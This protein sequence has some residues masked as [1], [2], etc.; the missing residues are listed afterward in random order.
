MKTL[1]IMWI[2]IAMS[3]SFF[4]LPPP[5]TG[6]SQIP[7]NSNTQM[8]DEI[9]VYKKVKPILLFNPNSKILIKVES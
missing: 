9:T 8:M 6:Q 7:F 3:L 2:G 5:A 4:F 1:T